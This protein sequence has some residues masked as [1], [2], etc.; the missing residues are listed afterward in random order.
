MYEGT[1]AGESITTETD[2]LSSIFAT[3]SVRLT[4]WVYNRLDRADWHLA[5]DL[6]QETFVWLLELGGVGDLS[7][8]EA[9]AVL[10]M[11]ARH[12]IDDHYRQMG[13]EPMDLGDLA[14]DDQAPVEASA[15]DTALANI[16]VLAMLTEVPAPLEVAA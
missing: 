16:V 11:L 15:E 7:V 9:G 12:V 8:D 6:V 1:A 4:R 14:Q 2:Q 5:E 3:H 13:P 10:E